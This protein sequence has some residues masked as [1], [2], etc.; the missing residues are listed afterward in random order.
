MDD[1]RRLTSINLSFCI[2]TVYQGSH[3]EYSEVNW[4]AFTGCCLIQFVFCRRSEELRRNSIASGMYFSVQSTS[5]T[6]TK[7]WATL[8]TGPGKW[9][10]I[11][12]T[13]AFVIFF[14][15]YYVIH[16]LLYSINLALHE[17]ARW[18]VFAYFEPYEYCCCFSP[19]PFISFILFSPHPST[20]TSTRQK[21]LSCSTSMGYRLFTWKPGALL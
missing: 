7:P 20:T 6:Q 8:L 1:V 14:C 10:K 5:Q 21:S 17:G 3:H 12:K 15:V 11:T 16:T 18:S 4:R 2:P 9:S 19:F 13:E